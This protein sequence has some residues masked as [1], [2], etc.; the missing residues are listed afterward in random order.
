MSEH[1]YRK[2]KRIAA[3]ELPEKYN[4][5]L[6]L[7][8]NDTLDSVTTVDASKSGFGFLS[9][10]PI[11]NYKTGSEVALYPFGKNIPIYAQ[12][13]FSKQQYKYTRVGTK[14][15]PYGNYQKYLDELSKI[16]E[17]RD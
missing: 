8:P 11:K 15:L 1:E 13:V 12:V 4:S 7:L 17:S 6:V 14:L 16:I 10:F 5:F 2:E 3:V 9:E